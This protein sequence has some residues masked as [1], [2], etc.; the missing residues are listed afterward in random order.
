MTCSKPAYAKVTVEVFFIFR[1]AEQP[2]QELL[3][4]ACST[5]I[6]FSWAGTATRVLLLEVLIY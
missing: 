4:L 2:D 6:A 3:R 5:R 1:G